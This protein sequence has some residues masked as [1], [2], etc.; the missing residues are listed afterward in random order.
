MWA[1]K[2]EKKSTSL[3]LKISLFLAQESKIF[4]ILMECV[5]SFGRTLPLKSR[6]CRWQCINRNS[7]EE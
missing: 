5:K 1:L 3:F 2:G 7:D 4:W 6:F